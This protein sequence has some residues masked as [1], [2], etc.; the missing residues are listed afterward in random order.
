MT[1]EHETPDQQ[2]YDQQGYG[3]PSYLDPSY[4]DTDTEPS[5]E[6][7]AA[8]EAA[9]ESEFGAALGQAHDQAAQVMEPLKSDVLAR[10][11]QSLEDESIG[12]RRRDRRRHLRILF[13]VVNLVAI[14][15]I[16]VTYVMTQAAIR[17][18]ETEGRIL[19][20]QTEVVTLTRA[21]VRE[22]AEDKSA[23]VPN[24]LPE[25]IMRVAKTK[26]NPDGYPFSKRRLRDGTYVD[27][28]GRPYRV[29][30]ERDRLLF[31]SLGPNGR[32]EFGQG[33][34]ITDQWVTF[35]R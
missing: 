10:V 32:D 1:T 30:S 34:D 22:L 16:C 3:D 21:L 13:Y 35:V 26:A 17:L 18:K 9:F 23:P 8:L 12:A 6:E 4:L 11:R 7:L 29:L 27:D 2:D 19:A 28:F 20:T 24:N 33:D 31:Y 25:L 14:V 15:M 5:P